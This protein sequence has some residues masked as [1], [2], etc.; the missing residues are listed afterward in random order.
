MRRL[1]ALFPIGLVLGAAIVHA[2]GAQ[3]APTAITECQTISQSGSYVLANNITAI[4]CLEIT[5]S[6]VTIDLAGFTV[7]GRARGILASAN[8]QGIT[9]RNGSVIIQGVFGTGV[10]LPG[11]GSI[12][13]GLHIFLARPATGISAKGI[14]RGN[15]VVAG[16]LVPALASAVGISASGTITDNYVNGSGSGLG[17]SGLGQLTGIEANGTVRGNTAINNSSGITVGVGSTVI[18][19][20]ATGNTV[21]GIEADCPTNLTDNTAVNNGTNLLLNGTGCNNTNNVA[22]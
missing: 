4:G 19:N 8:T 10:D 21:V 6:N 12:V 9:V 17:R 5:V 2:P 1:A 3:A 15:T 11:D 16:P 22:P 18:G 7:T 14:V 20:T 13:E